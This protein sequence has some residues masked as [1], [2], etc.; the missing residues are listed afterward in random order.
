VF[1]AFVK[2]LGIYPVGSLV[3]LQS[4]RLAVVT[5]QN[6]QSLATPTVK[7]FFSTKSNMPVALQVLDL[8]RSNDKIVSREDPKTWGFPHLDELWAGEMAP[9]RS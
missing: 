3:R 4:G 9:K 5:E 7:V 2:S 6:P 1:K 8:A